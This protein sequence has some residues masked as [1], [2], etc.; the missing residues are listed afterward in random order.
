MGLK[1]YNVTLLRSPD[2]VI[3]LSDTMRESAQ[4]RAFGLSRSTQIHLRKRQPLCFIDFSS[5]RFWCLV[6]DRLRGIISSTGLL[7]LSRID[8]RTQRSG[9]MSNETLVFMEDTMIN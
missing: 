7:L 2:R 1:K 9:T 8:Y 4:I 5:F 6:V 3:V